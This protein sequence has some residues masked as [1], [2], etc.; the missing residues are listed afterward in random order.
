MQE[1]CF[2]VYL[3]NKPQSPTYPSGSRWKILLR[4]EINLH[5]KDKQLLEQI[6]NFFGVGSIYYYGNSIHYLVRSVAELEIIIKHFDRYP[7][8]SK[9][10]ADFVLFK[11]VVNLVKDR[12]YSPEN[13]LKIASGA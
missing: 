12:D 1:G 13:I 3:V 4:F 7:L 11:S 10:Y 9:K 2:E 8:L 5:E 6:R